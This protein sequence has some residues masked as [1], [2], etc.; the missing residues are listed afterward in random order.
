MLTVF[1]RQQ[2][3]FC[4]GVSRRSFLRLG[5]LG[6][7]RGFGGLTLAHCLAANAGTANGK[8]PHSVIMVYLPGGLT[9]SDTFDMKPAAPR[10]VRGPFQPISTRVP[11]LRICELMPRMAQV[12]HK[13]ALVRTVVGFKDRHESFQCYTGRPG[14]R[15]GDG[16]PQGGWPTF[17]SVVSKLL[18]PSKAGM[19]PYIDVGPATGKIAY[20]NRGQHDG[21][22][23]SSWPGFL[24]FAHTPFHLEGQG[25]SDLVLNGISLDRMYHRKTLLQAVDRLRHQVDHSGM[26]DGIDAFH[27][28]A[29]GIL[30]SSKLAAAMDLSREDP[31][32]VERYGPAKPT[33]WQYEAAPKSPQHLLLARRLIEAGVR[34]V[35]VAF[36]AWD[37]HGDRGETLELM[38]REHLPDLDRA[39][40]TLIEDLDERG[41]LEQTTVVVWGEMGR[42]PRL[43]DKAGRDHWP[44]VSSALLCG[45]GV[46]QGVVV[47]ATDS[48]AAEPQDRPVHVQEVLATLYHNLGIDVSTAT[49]ADLSGRPHYLVDRGAVPIRELV[50]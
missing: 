3:A 35:T 42:T 31:H 47:G 33:R 39:L 12:M 25:K 4:D 6:L 17:G 19:P 32:I 18:G 45:G 9:Q 50:G 2:R 44:H 16:D 27:Q 34:I 14:G 24:G 36:G 1:G 5:T 29:I 38:A 46:Q 30:T 26:M 49:V 40:C 37:W 22:A 11:G 20:M 41:L 8:A 7:G 43:N 10:E 13:A 15:A 21:I 28:Q 48:Y 23:R